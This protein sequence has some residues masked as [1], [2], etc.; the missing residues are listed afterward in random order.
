MFIFS[1]NKSIDIYC[2]VYSDRLNIEYGGLEKILPESITRLH[3]FYPGRKVQLE[4]GVVNFM[5]L[6]GWKLVSATTQ[7]DGSSYDTTYLMKKEI[8]IT[9]TDYLLIMERYEKLRFR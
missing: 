9:E 4:M 6:H 8:E 2:K 7:R 3:L 5:S 1:Q